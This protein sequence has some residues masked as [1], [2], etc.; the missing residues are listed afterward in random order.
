MFE[1][2]DQLTGDQN[3]RT[4]IQRAGRMVL[5]PL[6]EVGIGMFVAVVVGGRQ[7]VMDILRDGK[8]RQAEQDNEHRQ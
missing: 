4:G 1:E 3:R 7:L 2:S 8:W 6:A 5:D